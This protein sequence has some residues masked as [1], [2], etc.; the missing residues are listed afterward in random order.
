MPTKDAELKQKLKG[1]LTNPLSMQEIIARLDVKRTDRVQTRRAIKALA[2]S[3]VIVRIKGG[4]YGLPDKM[5]LVTGIVQGH[6]DGY[7]FV[8]PDDAGQEDV[9]LSA[10]NFDEVMH[11]DRVVCRI[12]AS[13]KNGRREGRVIRVLERAHFTIAGSF[14]QLRHGGYVIPF[15]DRITHDFHID[16]DGTMDANDGDAVI[17]KIVEYPSRHRRAQAKITKILGDCND[18]QVEIKV[19]TAKFHIRSEFPPMAIN[20]A[21]SVSL[22]EDGY[23]PDRLDLRYRPIVTIDGETAQDFDDAVEVER[24]SDGQWKLGVHIA[25]VSHYVTEGSALDK[26]AFKRSVSVYFPGT[27]VPMLPLEL[28][29][30]LCSLNPKV[31][32]LTMSCI[33]TLNKTGEVVDYKIKQSVIRSVERMTYTDVA[34]ILEDNDSHTLG[35]Y[36]GLVEH[37]RNMETLAG[38]LRKRRAKQGALD[39]DLPEPQVVLDITGRAENIVRAKRNVA[40]RIIEEFMLAANRVVA[41]HLAL[42]SYPAIYR[43]HDKPD[44]F[45]VES[46][47][48]FLAAFGFRFKRKEGLTPKEMQ[49]ILTAVADKPEEK[50]VAHVMLRSMKQARY[51]GVNLGHFSL[52]FKHYAHF[53]SPIRRY[54]DLITHRLLKDLILGKKRKKYWQDAIPEIADHCSIAERTAEEA[55]RDIIKLRQTQYMADRVGEEFDGIISGVTS[56]GFFVEL[57][58]PAVEGLV[59]IT[60]IHDDYYIYKEEEHSLTGERTGK[61]FRLG[62]RVSIRVA[63]VLLDRRQ[64][65][66]EWIDKKS[67]RKKVSGKNSNKNEGRRP[68]ERRKSMKR[69]KKQA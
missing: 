45:K 44:S 24:S 7:G 48:E 36:G 42:N 2:D 8:I 56:F 40:H 64:I 39:F 38:L 52:A 65:D 57:N 19:V 47:K 15:D 20:E 68:R 13:H 59:R 18:P 11:G 30:G 12:E 28:S 62:D 31:D 61:R 4:R 22:P 33:M 16:D 1:L 23:Y 21:R 25:D 55:E 53:T 41:E 3:G 58:E 27:V 17:A 63:S 66:F 9:Y 6:R 14:D 60:S 67:K 49:E 35:R 46:L 5:N 50:L 54:P 29:H 43:V 32:R 10:R 51:S 37:F 34:A 69:R 26:E